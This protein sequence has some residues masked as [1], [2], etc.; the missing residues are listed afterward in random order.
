MLKVA[1]C[2]DEMTAQHQT[3]NM[4]VGFGIKYNQELDIISFSTGEE[5]LNAPFNYDILFLDI[6]LEAGC[7]GIRIGQQLRERNNNAIFILSTMVKDRYRDGYKAGVHRYLEKP[8]QQEEFDEAML[9][10]V[11]IL[12]HAPQKIDIHFKTETRLVNIEDILYIESYNRKRYV[13]LKND[14]LMTLETIDNLEK[15]LP[16]GLFYRPQKSFLIH[17][18]HVMKTNR[19]ELTMEDGRIIPFVKGTY[20]RFNQSLMQYLGGQK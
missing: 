16:K 11:R 1:V 15:R 9:S 5:L 10:A 14:T 12:Y 6:R 2:D 7:D 17:L 13:Y 8:F 18:G 4:L 19:T 20:D 3:R